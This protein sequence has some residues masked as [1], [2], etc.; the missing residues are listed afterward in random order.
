M[1]SDLFARCY[2]YN[3]TS[4]TSE[5]V[6]IVHLRHTYYKDYVDYIS[7]PNYALY[8]CGLVIILTWSNMVSSILCGLGI[9]LEF[10][11]QPCALENIMSPNDLISFIILQ[12]VR[13]IIYFRR[14]YSESVARLPAG[15]RNN[16]IV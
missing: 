1:H 6:I 16:N 10:P 11:S 15:Q 5:T 7:F 14:Y 4:G 9:P 3:F 13:I 12:L 2:S 8:L